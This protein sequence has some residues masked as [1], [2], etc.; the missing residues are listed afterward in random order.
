MLPKIYHATENEFTK[1]DDSKLGIESG[2]KD[3]RNG[4]CF[5]TQ[6][7]TAEAYFEDFQFIN[8]KNF[9]KEYGISFKEAENS[10]KIKD[11]TFKLKYGISYKDYSTCLSSV[12]RKIDS[13]FKDDIE[14]DVLRLKSFAGKLNPYSYKESSDIIDVR[15]L[16]VIKVVE[17]NLEEKDLKYI[18]MEND[19]WDENRQLTL[20]N[21]AKEEGYEGIVFQNMQDSGWFGGSGVDDIYQIFYSNHINIVGEIEYT[22]EGT[23]YKD[24]KEHVAKINKPK[25]NL[26]LN[27]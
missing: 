22:S 10:F 26:N 18:D 21:Q 24:L 20:G 16:G 17:L 9:E 14:L 4:F 11:D 15:P 5:S 23:E 19:S 2:S 7:R 8:K 3:T 12:R 25:S 13:K 6:T 1:F 27:R